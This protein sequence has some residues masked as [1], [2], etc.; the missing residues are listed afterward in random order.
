[1]QLQGMIDIIATERISLQLNRRTKTEII[2]I[3]VKCLQ[4]ETSLQS[5]RDYQSEASQQVQVCGY[6]DN[7]SKY[8]FTG[9]SL[10]KLIPPFVNDFHMLIIKYDN[11][12]HQLA[13]VSMKLEHLHYTNVNNAWLFNSRG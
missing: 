12:N 4:N 7:T 5:K 10:Q 2:T 6:T 3:T 13:L 1:M 8:I 9:F 11:K